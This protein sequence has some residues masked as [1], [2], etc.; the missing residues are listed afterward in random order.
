MTP[1]PPF[2]RFSSSRIGEG[3]TTSKRRKRKNAPICQYS[4]SGASSRISRNA[5]T[6]SQHMP[7]WSEMPRWRPVMSQAHTPTQNSMAT[8]ASMTHG[9]ATGPSSQ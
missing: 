8:T 1:N 4:S 7:P 3:F 9:E 5:T 2:M 6:S